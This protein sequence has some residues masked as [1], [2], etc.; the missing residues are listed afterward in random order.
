MERGGLPSLIFGARRPALAYF[1][2]RWLAI[3]DFWSAIA[4][5]GLI[6]KGPSASRQA[7]LFSKPV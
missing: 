4:L 1:G 7:F 2:V 6:K 3:A 5:A